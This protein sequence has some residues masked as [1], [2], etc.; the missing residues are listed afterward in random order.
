MLLALKEN[1]DVYKKNFKKISK[2]LVDD[3][4]KEKNKEVLEQYGDP[5]SA[6]NYSY[7]SYFY[8]NYV[9]PY[10]YVQEQRR[11]RKI[12]KGKNEEN[13]IAHRSGMYDSRAQVSDLTKTQVLPKKPKVNRVSF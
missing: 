13:L 5:S 12:V 8:D 3:I 2:L 10:Y 4:W 9:G 11:L 6:M 1:A 7:G